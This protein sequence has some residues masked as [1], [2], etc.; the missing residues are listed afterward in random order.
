[1]KLT[2]QDIELFKALSKSELGKNLVDYL[3]RLSD[4]ICDV[5]S[6]KPEDTKES[7]VKASAMIKEKIINKITKVN[8]LR[9][10]PAGQFE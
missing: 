8:D 9:E 1:M 10:T 3:N 2:K 4:H 7:V 6:M 5:R